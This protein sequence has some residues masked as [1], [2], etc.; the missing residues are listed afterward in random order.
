MHSSQTASV[1]SVGLFGI[2]MTWASSSHARL[3]EMMVGRV[4]HCGF[5][6]GISDGYFKGDIY[7][8][9]VTHRLQ[10]LEHLLLFD[11]HYPV[12]LLLLISGCLQPF[13]LW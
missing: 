12:T 9:L 6:N 4:S 11:T 8:H 3:A 1:W 2:A 5:L 10:R 7:Q 13:Q